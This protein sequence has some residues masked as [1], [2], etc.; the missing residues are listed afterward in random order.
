LKISIHSGQFKKFNFFVF[1]PNFKKK[2]KIK[3]RRFKNFK[4]HSFWFMYLQSP[5]KCWFIKVFTVWFV[6]LTH[7]NEFTNH[8]FGALIR[9]FIF[10][11][12]V[13]RYF[14]HSNECV[15]KHMISWINFLRLVFNNSFHSYFLYQYSKKIVSKYWYFLSGPW[16]F[17]TL[18]ISVVI[19][20]WSRLDTANDYQ[21][22]GSFIHHKC[23]T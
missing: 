18:L 14:W 15:L 22:R 20:W 7:E 10:H 17:R 16:S 2:I 3:K 12:L 6:D 4:S 21:T 5:S 19:M 13:Y 23:C 1:G 8:I 11:T 9:L